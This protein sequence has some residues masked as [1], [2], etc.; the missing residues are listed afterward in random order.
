M[1]THHIHFKMETALA[2][3]FQNHRGITPFT[4]Y[5]L[6]PDP[7]P[8]PYGY[9]DRCSQHDGASTGCAA[10]LM[11]AIEQFVRR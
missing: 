9:A 11:P 7:V 6:L 10:A 3:D 5:V 1:Q 2:L 8:S 4:V